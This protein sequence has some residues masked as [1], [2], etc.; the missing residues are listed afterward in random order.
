MSN[1]I[2]YALLFVGAVVI[3]ALASIFIS[4]LLRIAL[5]VALLA[6]AYYWFTRA[7]HVRKYRERR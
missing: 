4:F 6:I 3:L 2:R 5:L 1:L 7:V